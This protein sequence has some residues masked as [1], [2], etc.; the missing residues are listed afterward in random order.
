MTAAGVP[1][2]SSRFLGH[3]RAAVLQELEPE[4]QLCEKFAVLQ[5]CG[6]R[7][8]EIARKLPDETPAALKTA[9]LRLKKAAERLDAGD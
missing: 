9:E 1:A 4:I 3:V 2:R 7:R 8:S 5:A 6:Y